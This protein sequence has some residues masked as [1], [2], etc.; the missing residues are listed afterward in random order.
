M[1]RLPKTLLVC[2]M[3]S[4]EEMELAQGLKEK[5]PPFT[6][7]RQCNTLEELVEALEEKKG[8]TIM[9]VETSFTFSGTLT[10][11][12]KAKLHLGSSIERAKSAKK[13]LKGLP[14]T[15]KRDLKN[16]GVRV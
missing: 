1:T 4:G 10:A 2:E 9:I 7:L 3:K 6:L 12:L 15:I 5:S 16:I 14:W 11:A 13:T 8:D